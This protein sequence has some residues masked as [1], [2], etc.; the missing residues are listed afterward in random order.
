MFS[1]HIRKNGVAIYKIGEEEV[2]GRQLYLE[3]FIR[4]AY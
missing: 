3:M 1:S 2:W 4:D